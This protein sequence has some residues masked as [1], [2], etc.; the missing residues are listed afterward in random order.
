MADARSYPARPFLAVSA[1]IIR[2]GKFLDLPLA[3][4]LPANTAGAKAAFGSATKIKAR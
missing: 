3:G 1:A 4:S 2:D